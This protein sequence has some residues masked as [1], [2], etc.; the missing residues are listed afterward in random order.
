MSLVFLC[1]QVES[2]IH[3]F[4][5]DSGRHPFTTL[6]PLCKMNGLKN[7]MVKMM[8]IF[9][10][11]NLNT[12]SLRSR[13]AYDGR[14]CWSPSKVCL[15]AAVPSEGVMGPGQA[16]NSQPGECSVRGGPYISVPDCLVDEMRSA[17]LEGQSG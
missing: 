9:P 7:R 17:V 11:R 8:K 1:C 3:I 15:F 5:L 4:V 16:L 12:P 14:M 10:V 2:G 6:V 13:I